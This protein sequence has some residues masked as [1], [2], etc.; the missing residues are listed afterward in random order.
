MNVN[1]QL[2]PTV[3][4]I[5]GGTGDLAWRKLVPALFDL[6]RDRSLPPHFSVIVL[7]RGKL[8]EDK[9]RHHLRDGVRKFSRRG[10][11]KAEKWNQFANHV[12]YLQGDYK[13]LQT[14]STL[15]DQCTKLEKEWRAK[16]QRIFY[17]ATSP[18]MFGERK[19]DLDRPSGRLR[20]RP[21]DGGHA[22]SQGDAG[23][24]CGTVCHQ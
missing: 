5:F 15:A 3:F 18:L 8:A 2:E 9:L 16:A 7:G 21:G 23:R 24:S 11:V 19:H 14:Y 1:D 4:A 6:S 17:M 12:H 22:H 10:K 13:K 20:R